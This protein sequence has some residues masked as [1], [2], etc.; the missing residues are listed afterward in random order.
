MVNK[1]ELG[2]L[3]E[4]NP[5]GKRKPVLLRYLLVRYDILGVKYHQVYGVATRVLSTT[6]N[7]HYSPFLYQKYTSSYNKIRI[8]NYT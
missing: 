6:E 4:I 3:M 2:A 8:A 5:N 1:I 7:V